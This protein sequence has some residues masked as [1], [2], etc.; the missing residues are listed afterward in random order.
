[1]H[2]QIKIYQYKICTINRIYFV[3]C[4]SYQKSGKHR[5]LL[6]CGVSCWNNCAA[7]PI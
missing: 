1:M 5:F 4:Y 6:V 3:V 2:V 7:C